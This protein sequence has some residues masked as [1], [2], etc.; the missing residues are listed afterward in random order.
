[1]CNLVYKNFIFSVQEFMVLCAWTGIEQLH[2][3]QGSQQEKM[4][5]EELNLVLFQLYQKEILYWNNDTYELKQEVAQLFRDIRFASA[6]LQ[7]Y[8]RTS[9]SPL[10]CF[11]GTYMIVMEL[12]GND[13]DAVKVHRLQE[14]DFFAELRNKGMLPLRDSQEMEGTA[15]REDCEAWCSILGKRSNLMENGCILYD[16]LQ[17]L[18]RDAKDLWVAITIHDRK[19][20][21]DRGV[22]LIAEQDFSDC[23][24]CIAD[25]V[26][27]ADYYTL[28]SLSQLLR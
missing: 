13:T 26:V 22:V 28:D 3:L 17:E 20:G 15:Q 9:R 21:Q 18:L 6:E 25:S 7:I 19:S 16:R 5:G 10:L 23:L 4:G 14:Y 2:I 27:R 12:S 24:I 8:T 11:Y 1:M